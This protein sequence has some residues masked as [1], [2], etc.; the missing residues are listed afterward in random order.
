M[1]FFLSAC[2]LFLLMFSCNRGVDK[3]DNNIPVIDV[4]SSVG[5]GRVVDLS[6]VASG[7]KYIPLETDSNSLVGS[8]PLVF[9]ENERIYT[10][11]SLKSQ[12]I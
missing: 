1:N 4:G 5:K 10:L 8:F 3:S 9:F 7:I 6:E 2:L 12:G 11:D